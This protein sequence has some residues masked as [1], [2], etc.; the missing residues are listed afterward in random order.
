M[1]VSSDPD[2]IALARYDNSLTKLLE[3]YPDGC[4]DHVAAKALGLTEEEYQAR[5]EAIVARI[6]AGLT[7]AE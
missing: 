3:R 6:R 7:G 2:Y 5:Y 1:S 4:P